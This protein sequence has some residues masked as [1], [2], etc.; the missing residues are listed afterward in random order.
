MAEVTGRL[1]RR[2][3]RDFPEPG[4][5]DEV[6]CLVGEASDSE[7]IQSAI[8]FRASGDIARLRDAVALTAADWRDT[9]VGA[10]LADDDWSDKLDAALGT[11]TG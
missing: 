11:S 10:G 4:S 8:V 2:I 5:A 1:R 9:L 7:R 6:T 3:E